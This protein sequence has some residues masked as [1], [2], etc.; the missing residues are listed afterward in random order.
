L[1][2]IVEDVCWKFNLGCW[3]SACVAKL[4]GL[5]KLANHYIRIAHMAAKKLEKLTAHKLLSYS[6]LSHHEWNL[7]A[8]TY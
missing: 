2:S 3:N 7:A 6:V 8:N 1:Q 5:M 4:K